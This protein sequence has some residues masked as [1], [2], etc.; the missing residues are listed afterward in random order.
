VSNPRTNLWRYPLYLT[1]G[2]TP[3]FVPVIVLFWHSCGLDALDIYLLQ[4]LFALA[5]VVLEVPTG[6]VADRL[7]K[8]VSLLVGSALV[9]AG[10][11]A[12]ALSSTFWAFLVGEIVL[13]VGITLQSG[14]DSALLYDTLRSEGRQDEYQ[15]HEGRARA[16]QMIAMAACA[17]VG[18]FVG[19]HSLRATLWMSVAG[20]VLA[21]VVALG[22]VEIRGADPYNQTLRPTTR[23]LVVG[24][25]QFLRKHRL[26]RW[27]VLFFAV[28]TGSSGWLLWVYQ[29]YMEYT[30][31]PIYAF[32]LAF[33]VFGLFAALCSMNAHR[34]DSALGKK[35]SLVGLA[36]LQVAPPVLM[37]L[38]VTPASFLFI[39]GHQAVRGISR[40]VLSERILD[41]TF[42][43]RR[44]TVLSLAS[45]A[46]RLF[47]GLTAALVGWMVHAL[48]MERALLGQGA[49]LVGF[50]AVLAVMYL[51]I[52]S[53]YFR[54]KE[55]VKQRQ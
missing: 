37:A 2:M 21:F 4:G 27:Y 25:L 35:G 23:S 16:W 24:S 9:A 17:V 54:V 6:T 20:P 36:A 32:G 1:T 47:M 33:A 38:V 10:L 52:P 3:F 45:L 15:R 48:P 12:Y 7:G 40:T 19:E 41:Y 55:S 39:L 53:K 34:Y 18:G 8:R 43:D 50:L 44:A 42:A 49:L 28:L 26:V 46:G 5:V 13:A 31:L 11:V 29:P 30:G 51:R 22:F 14:A